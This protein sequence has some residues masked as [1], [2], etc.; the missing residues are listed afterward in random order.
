MPKKKARKL[1]ELLEAA[2]QDAT[3]SVA[4][5]RQ[6]AFFMALLDATVYSHVPREPAPA[7]R[8]RFHQFVR[9]DNGQTVMP[10]FTD[11]EQAEFASTGNVGIM[12]MGARRFFELTRGATLML[13][14]NLDKITLYPP[15]IK[16]LLNGQPPPFFTREELQAHEEVGVCL[17]TVPTDSM[18]LGLSGL[19]AREP[20]VRAAYLTEIHRGVDDSG[21][22]LLLTL[23]V[24]CGNEERMVQLT[25]L[26]LHSIS[27][28]LTLPVTMSCQAPDE[29]LPALCHHGIQFYGT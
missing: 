25:T 16:A 18:V 28:P 4:A 10:F 26:E 13:N 19:F 15:E 9:P 3:P 29:P 8:M 14:P 6:E 1:N 27:P 11:R 20:S 22:F 24:T 2:R 5:R 7:G 17:P 21:V 12:A 23:V